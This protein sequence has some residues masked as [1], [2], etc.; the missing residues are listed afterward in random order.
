M[1]GKTA[2]NMD[3]GEVEKFAGMAGQWWDPDGELATLHAINPL[4]LKFITDTVN[5]KNLKVLDLGCGGGILTE[6]LAKEGANAKGADL[7]EASLRV[8]REHA[9][10]SSLEIDYENISGEELAMREEESYDVV[11]CMELLEHVPDPSSIMQSVG[12]LVKPGGHAF[13]STL[14][15]NPK[16]FLQAI[17]AAE[18]LLRMLKPGTHD[19][20]KFITPAEMARMARNAGLRP[21]KLS[22]FGYNVLTDKYFP[23]ENTDVNYFMACIKDPV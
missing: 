16:S 9:K 20:R 18:Y 17:V 1:T 15:R 13:L 23:R 21:I 22:G 4:R 14:N 3:P 6:A 7:A 12:R 19:F 10:K 11:V 8:A 5:L 2:E